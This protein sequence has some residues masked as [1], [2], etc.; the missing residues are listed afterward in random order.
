ML[1]VNSFASD[2]DVRQNCDGDRAVIKQDAGNSS[3]RGP[4]EALAMTSADPSVPI[5]L[6]FHPFEGPSLTQMLC[7]SEPRCTQN[8]M[9]VKSAL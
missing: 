4:S 1:L 2:S 3:L 8:E 9:W 7:S 5:R 6:V